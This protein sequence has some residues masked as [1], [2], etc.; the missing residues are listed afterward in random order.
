[1]KA[2]RVFHPG[3]A[4]AEDR[5]PSWRGGILGRC[6]D[7]F[8]RTPLLPL[9]LEGWKQPEGLGGERARGF[10]RM[11]GDAL[12]LTLKHVALQQLGNFPV[13]RSL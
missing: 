3:T 9:R 4:D 10:P 12:L 11:K 8:C 5:G 13:H 6:L 2:T 1:M 7:V